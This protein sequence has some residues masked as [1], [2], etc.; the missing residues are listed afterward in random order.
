MA[1]SSNREGNKEVFKWSDENRCILCEVCL[2]FIEDNGK[3]QFFKWREIQMEVEKKIGHKFSTP[4]SC[5]H[6]YD[7]MRKDY[8]IWKKLRESETGLGWDPKTGKIDA[9][10][11][12]WQ[13]KIKVCI[14]ILPNNFVH[15]NN[16]YII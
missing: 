5:K 4:S 7:T 8:R 13:I 12:W 6:E 3:A 10:N 2:K 9:S 11:E 14:F 1:S 16:Y 15:K